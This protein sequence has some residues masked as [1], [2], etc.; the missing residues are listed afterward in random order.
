MESWSF[1]VKDL[2][3]FA[4][5]MK[6]G[7]LDSRHARD[8]SLLSLIRIIG[9][10][11]VWNALSILIAM[12][13][14]DTLWSS[15]LSS[16]NLKYKFDRIFFFC[17]NTRKEWPAFCQFQ[18]FSSVCEHRQV[19]EDDARGKELNVQELGARVNWE[20]CPGG[21]DNPAHYVDGD[22]LVYSIDRSV[23][24]DKGD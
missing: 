7:S 23:A 9:D 2:A 11:M 5:I 21:L 17:T 14:N 16:L 24:V 18:L 4:K 12:I 1:Q 13:F 20:K 3:N 22:I 19:Q 6:Q 8:P 15:S 10:N